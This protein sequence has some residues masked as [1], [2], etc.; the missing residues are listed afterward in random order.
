MT[1][2]SRTALLAKLPYEPPMRF[3][4]EIREV[5][6][7]HIVGCYGWTEEDC[8]GHFRDNLIVPGVKILECAAQTGCVAWGLYHL[9]RS[10]AP[11]EIAEYV[12]LFT[13]VERAVFKRTVRPRQLVRVEASFG[14]D[15]Y[16]R[17]NKIVCEVVVRCEG[18]PCDGEE[19]FRGV[20][21]GMWVPRAQIDDSEGRVA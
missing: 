2:L 7:D 19:V 15:G 1:P 20:L 21:A 17:G 16:F 12:G 10:V 11:E 18:G 4:T 13:S 8:A 6:A 9:S 5:D 3:V 14:E